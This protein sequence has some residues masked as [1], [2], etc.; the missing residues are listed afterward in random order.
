MSIK[1]RLLLAT[2]ISILAIFVLFG[3]VAC[4]GVTLKL[5]NL[6]GIGKSSQANSI[7]DLQRQIAG[8]G[9][10]T[11]ELTYPAGQSPKVFT[12]GWV[13]GARCLINPGQADQKD[14]SNLVKWSGS[15]SFEP[16][17]GPLSH[18]SFSGEGSNTIILTVSAGS[19]SMSTQYNVSAI[20][21][22]NY[23]HI[24]SQA[25]CPADGHG[26][27][28]DPH[29]VKGKI[30]IGSLNVQVDGKPAARVGDTGVH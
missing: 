19:Q 13:F 26:S 18:P 6:P 1:R 7:G 12:K 4:K 10:V 25:W 17:T 27:P 2:S 23:A 30:T 15:G 28:G 14:I 8:V 21:P 22:A 9:L 5:P 29:S 16:A 20:S 3:S 11:I 24:D